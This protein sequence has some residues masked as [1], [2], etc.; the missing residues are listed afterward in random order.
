MNPNMIQSAFLH[1]KIVKEIYSTIQP[2][3]SIYD[4]AKRIEGYI[5]SECVRSECKKEINDGIAFPVGLCIN[6]CVAHYTPL[7]N[8]PN[9]ILQDGDLL[10]IDFGIHIHGEITD[11][12][13]TL[14]IGP[15]AQKFNDLIDISKKATMIGVKMSSVD[16]LLSEIGEAIQ[17]YVESKEIEVDGKTYSLKTFPELCGHSIAPFMIHSG[18]AV[19]N[20]KINFPY[21]LRMKDGEK[22]AIEPFVTTGSGVCRYQGPCNHYMLSRN[23]QQIFEMK[24]NKLPDALQLYYKNIYRYYKSLPFS[25]R[26]CLEN[27]E[28]KASSTLERLVKE[29]ILDEFL[30]IYDIEGS[31]VAHHEHNVFISEKGNIHLTKNP[32]Y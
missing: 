3:D 9:L 8:D 26:W 22:Y 2:G 16:Q 24:K 30:P 1:K 31:Y 17:E 5:R 13:F 11:S 10:K 23:H 20:C 7:P 21:T 28:L 25:N 12:A 19:P 15:S 27:D 29:E 32:Y 14:P 6:H 4:I 18:K